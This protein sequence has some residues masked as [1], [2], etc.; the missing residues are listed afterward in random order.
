MKRAALWA[1]TVVCIVSFGATSFAQQAA[2]PAAKPVFTKPVQGLAVINVLKPV[3]KVKGNEVVTTL[4]VKNASVG[5]IAGL[6]LDEYWYDKAGNVVTGD[7]KRMP[8]PLQPGEIYVFELHSPKDPRMNR[9][10]YQFSH[11]NG[12]IKAES[13]AKF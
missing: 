12:K 3:T 13:V 5:A 11:A 2:A 9:N 1:L 4:S 10:S 7:S 8:K 6:K